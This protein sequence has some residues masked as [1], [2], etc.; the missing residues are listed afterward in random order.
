MNT[1]DDDVQDMETSYNTSSLKTS[2]TWTVNIHSC[3][4]NTEVWKE[5]EHS[6]ACER[7]NNSKHFAAEIWKYLPNSQREFETALH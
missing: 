1:H 6:T 5:R 4:K 2:K 7:Q 3:S